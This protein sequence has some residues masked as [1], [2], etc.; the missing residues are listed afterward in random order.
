M[1]STNSF[2]TLQDDRLTAVAAIYGDCL[3]SLC[4]VEKYAI[5]ADIAA[6]GD[7]CCSYNEEDWSTFGQFVGAWGS[8]SKDYDAYGLLT[9]PECD[10]TDPVY[11]MPL[12]VAIAH[13]IAE[14]IYLP[15][16]AE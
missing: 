11:A 9:H 5:L 6:W 3:E 2:I 4:L 14:G 16:D 8:T 12:V 13:Q 15:E 1:A 10:W 7:Q